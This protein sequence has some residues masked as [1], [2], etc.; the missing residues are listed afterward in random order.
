MNKEKPINA[1]T[2]HI[3]NW[4]CL[5]YVVGLIW[6]FPLSCFILPLTVWLLSKNDHER[7]DL[8]GKNILN[9]QLTW[10]AAILGTWLLLILLPLGRYFLFG[11][12]LYFLVPAIIT[13]VGI[14]LM[15]IGGIAAYMGNIYLF[16][17]SYKF[18][19]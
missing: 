5:L 9:F 11:F 6:V 8:H 15:V 18:I 12:W 16:P 7:I 17:F 1:F 13:I 2:I 19:K 3:N 4:C 14:I 10:G